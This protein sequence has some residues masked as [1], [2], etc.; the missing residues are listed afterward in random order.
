VKLS[1][2]TYNKWRRFFTNEAGF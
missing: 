2:V 1:T